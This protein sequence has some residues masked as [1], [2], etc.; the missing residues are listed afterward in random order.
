MLSKMVSSKLVDMDLARLSRG[1]TDTSM[2]PPVSTALIPLLLSVFYVR[3]RT[4]SPDSDAAFR[5]FIHVINLG[6]LKQFLLWPR[7]LKLQ[8]PQFQ[9]KGTGR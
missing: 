8:Q 1:N 3:I 5:L 9:G 7:I 2:G 4:S 6:R